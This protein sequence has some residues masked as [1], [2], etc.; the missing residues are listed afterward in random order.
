MPLFSPIFGG[1]GTEEKVQKGGIFDKIKNGFLSNTEPSHRPP[2]PAAMTERSTS[3][4][5][6]SLSSSL[7]MLTIT[8]AISA[9]IENYI[10]ARHTLCETARLQQ[11]FLPGRLSKLPADTTSLDEALQEAI[12]ELTQL[13][14]RHAM[15]D[16]Q[17]QTMSLDDSVC[18]LFEHESGVFISHQTPR[19][20]SL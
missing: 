4:G 8:N 9:L 10:I 7:A 1:G 20:I 6:Q 13:K 18:E 2:T 12:E 14:E 5:F 16:Q 17:L 15:N 19:A 3:P 11:S